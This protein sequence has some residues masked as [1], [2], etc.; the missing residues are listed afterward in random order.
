MEK[1]LVC[2]T[3]YQVVH[4]VKSAHG[5]GKRFNSMTNGTENTLRRNP[6]IQRRKGFKSYGTQVLNHCMPP[7][8]AKE[9][10]GPQYQG[11]STRL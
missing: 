5:K 2:V 9:H 10:F 4:Q 8:S 6:E 11:Q 1:S 7:H 3:S